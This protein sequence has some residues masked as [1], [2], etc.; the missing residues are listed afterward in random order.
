MFTH[1][2]TPHN[3]IVSLA[4]LEIMR[5]VRICCSVNHHWVVAIPFQFLAKFSYVL[6]CDQ[7]ERKPSWTVKLVQHT[8]CSWEE[9]GIHP[10]YLRA[11]MSIKSLL[12]KLRF[13]LAELMEW[14]APTYVT[15]FFNLVPWPKMYTHKERGS[16]DNV[17]FC[18]GPM[19]SMST[20][21]NNLSEFS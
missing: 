10:T 18:L 16:G 4:C 9:D 1:I 14:D 11:N 13:P 6:H 20:M 8:K 21:W 12:W 19:T 15:H 3:K 17:A 5:E 7:I 2:S